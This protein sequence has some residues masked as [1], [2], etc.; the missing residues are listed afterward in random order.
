MLMVDVDGVLVKGRSPDGLHWSA[1]LKED[2][3][4]DPDVLKQ[5]F[6]AIHFEDVVTG[7]SGLRETLA[8][9]LGQIGGEVSV[10]DL[11]T[12]WFS[13]DSRLDEQLLADLALARS[14]GC[15][16][17]IA[18]NQE[19]LRAHY[20]MSELGIGAVA[21][22]ISLFGGAGVPETRFALL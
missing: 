12:Y 21:D 13:R 19:H 1:G 6:F 5:R 18:T 16:V 10:D 20:L 7:R 15:S 9:I 4:V 14:V 22:A 2:L 11:L 3:G 17:Q 8:P